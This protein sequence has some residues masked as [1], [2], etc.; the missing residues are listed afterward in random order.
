MARLASV[1]VRQPTPETDLASRVRLVLDI[2]KL[3]QPVE[4]PCLRFRGRGQERAEEAPSDR[5]LTRDRLKV[6]VEAESLLK[7][8]GPRLVKRIDLR[9]PLELRP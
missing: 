3:E 5:V 9:S 2:G 1:R 7:L 6:A 8:A 4:E